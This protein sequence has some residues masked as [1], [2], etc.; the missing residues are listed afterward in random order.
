MQVSIQSNWQVS[1]LCRPSLQTRTCSHQCT[2]HVCHS[3]RAIRTMRWTLLLK[4][5]YDYAVM[6]CAISC[7]GAWG[8]SY[9]VLLSCLSSHLPS[10]SVHWSKKYIAGGNN[11]S[12]SKNWHSRIYFS[13]GS[14]SLCAYYLVPHCFASLVVHGHT[15]PILSFTY[16]F[17][18]PTAF[19]VLPVNSLKTNSYT[20]VHG[21][22][23]SGSGS[24]YFSC[25]VACLL[26]ERG[27]SHGIDVNSDTVKHSQDCCQ[28]WYDNILLRRGAG[29]ENLPTI[30]RLVWLSWCVY[31]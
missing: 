13:T 27:L 5:R 15:Y 1:C 28:R 12:R 16:H 17:C 14:V 18:L 22:R 2:S 20:N 24:G 9:E 4:H 25:L 26:G 19:T 6:R 30:S 11:C 3:S 31:V 8:N 10:Q 21:V 7:P 29:E 23:Q